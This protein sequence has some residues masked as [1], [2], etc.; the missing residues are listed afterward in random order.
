MTE[1]NRLMA[2]SLMPFSPCA[3]QRSTIGHWT[4]F[5]FSHKRF[6]SGST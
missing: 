2:Q 6:G 1:K 3:C 4:V 5:L